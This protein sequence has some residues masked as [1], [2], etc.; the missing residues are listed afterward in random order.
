MHYLIT[1]IE[2]DSEGE[3]LE[4][5]QL[6]DN[7]LMLNVPNPTVDEDLENNIGIALS[8]AFGFNVYSFKFSLLVKEDYTHIGGRGALFLPRLAVVPN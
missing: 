2:W 5:C 8:D 6:P 1:E 4:E 3:T 7:V